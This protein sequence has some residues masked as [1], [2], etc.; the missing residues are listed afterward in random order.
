MKEKVIDMLEE[1]P[2]I[3]AI[4]DDDGLI[5]CIE[6]PSRVIFV[7]YGDICNI[8]GI[9]KKLKDHGKYV[10]VHI[11]LV[12]GLES[13]AI[14]V[15]YLK[16]NTDID[17][18][19]S[20]KSL[21]VKAAKKEGLTTVMRFFALDSMSFESIKKHADTGVVDFIEVLPGIAPKAIGKL[22]ESIDIPVIAGG[23]ISD[24]ED[25]IAVLQSGAIAISSTNQRVWEL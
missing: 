6:S 17:G 16:E 19:I 7:L 3:A 22:A 1:M 8:G 13:K 10:I 2:I 23:L 21:V 25:V 12:E 9:V 14:S 11:D 20:T 24:K 4:K 18:I 5:K 15:R